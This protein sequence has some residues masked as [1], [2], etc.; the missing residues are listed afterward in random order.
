MVD[1]PSERLHLADLLVEHRRL[2]DLRGHEREHRR[3][4]HEENDAEHAQETR[5]RRHVGVGGARGEKDAGDP[6]HEAFGCSWRR[7]VRRHRYRHLSHLF[8]LGKYDR[9]VTGVL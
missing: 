4:R 1:G 5:L 9:C 2:A 7:H 6:P 8:Y 3:G